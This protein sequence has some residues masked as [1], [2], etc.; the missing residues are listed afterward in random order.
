MGFK[1]AEWHS[2]LTYKQTCPQ[3]Q[4]I[5]QYNDFNLDYRPWFP[6]GFV[7]CPTC[8]KP[9]RHNECYAIDADKRPILQV[10][11]TTSTC[12]PAQPI[13]SAPAY[14]SRFC[15]TC[16]HQFTNNTDAFCNHCGTK[17]T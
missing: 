6:D 16:G 15:G 11:L 14:V 4:T 1:R 10:D 17:R 9:L 12:S 3:C 8:K 2:G 13:Y 7:Y 5:V